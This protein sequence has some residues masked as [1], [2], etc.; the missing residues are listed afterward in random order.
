MNRSI[1]KATT[2]PRKQYKVDLLPYFL[3]LP[4]IALIGGIIFYP[5]L[6]GVYYSLREG[7]LLRL[8]G[9]VGLNNYLTLF[10]QP[11]F[12]NA[13]YF[14]LIFAAFN[15]FGCYA[16][17][18]V[19]AMMLNQNIPAQGFLRVCLLLPWVI[20]SVVSMMSW[21]W[22]IADEK[23]FV[24]IVL[25]A[26]GIGPIYFLSTPSLAIFSVIMVKIWRSF[27]FM[28]LSLLAALQT[29]DR[30]LYEAAQLDGASRWQLFRYITFPHLTGISVV[31]W[32]LMT[33]WTVN[34]FDTPFLLTQG[35]PS[36]ATEN[37]VLLAFRYTFRSNDVGLGSAVAV[38][39][40]II[41]MV[42]ALILLRQ[43]RR[44]VS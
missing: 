33:I 17:G 23:G 25:N 21:R 16:V 10:K 11:D 24:N 14:S 43:Q 40:L 32:I 28:M 6:T 36:N 4:S 22:L 5:F 26:L 13:L 37:L 31:L 7:S 20:P 34:D 9:F 15:V 12:R 39:S 18:L 30:N 29:I 35:G 38:V 8:E 42:L 3:L 27:P 19:L 41:L 44:G 2:L 1:T